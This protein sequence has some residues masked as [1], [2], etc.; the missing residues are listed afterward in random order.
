[1]T[2]CPA[3]ELVCLPHLKRGDTWR[4]AFVWQQADGTPVDLTDG[5]AAL[6]IRAVR[7]RLV[8]IPDDL[9]LELATGTVRVTFAAETTALIPA[10]V[11]YTDLQMTL[12]DG[13]VRSSQTCVLPVLEDQTR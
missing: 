2:A 9:T 4:L 6:Q 8:G 13:E 3:P 10:G 5:T 12:A 11:H 7:G 1:M